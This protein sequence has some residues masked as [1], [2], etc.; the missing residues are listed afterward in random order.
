MAKE[1]LKGKVDKFEEGDRAAEAFEREVIKISDSKAKFPEKIEKMTMALW[2][3]VKPWDLKAD[4]RVISLM[5][6]SAG[7]E[8]EDMVVQEIDSIQSGAGDFEKKK[9]LLIA[10]QDEMIVI[11]WLAEGFKSSIK[12]KI[13]FAIADL[14]LNQFQ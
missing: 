5:G 7:A 14:K 13:A 8:I 11:P 2:K 3:A 10:L 1:D 9:A 12:V 4:D 6:I